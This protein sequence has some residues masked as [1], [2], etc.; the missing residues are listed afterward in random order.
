MAQ[1]SG[2]RSRVRS[3]NAARKTAAAS[4]SRAVSPSRSPRARSAAPSSFWVSAQ[5]RGARSRVRSSRAARQAV[6]ASCSRAVPLSR[7]PRLR[8]AWPRLFWVIA[9]SS[10]TRSRGPFLQ[11]RAEGSHGGLRAAPCRFAFPQRPKGGRRGC[12]GSSP[13]QAARARG[14]ALRARRD[15]HPPPLRAAPC[16]SR[17]RRA[18]ERVSQVHLARRP[19]EGRPLAGPLLERGAVGPHRLLEPRR[20][21]LPRAEGGE[22][23]AEV[24]LCH[25][26]A[27]G[28]CARV[29]TAPARAP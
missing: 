14:S 25:R 26:P 28:R 12:S 18:P 22:H 27:A 20:A 13:R 7:S 24:H 8:S 11:R 6:T 2:T 1:S 4:S 15:R 5:P 9:Q 16:R 17:A 19:V 10:G 23:V 29:S 21:P 3:C